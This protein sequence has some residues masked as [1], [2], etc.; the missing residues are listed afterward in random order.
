MEDGTQLLDLQGLGEFLGVETPIIKEE[1]KVESEIK[2]VDDLFDKKEETLTEES[3]KTEPIKKEE[4]RQEEVQAPKGSD[5]SELVK[6]L[7]EKG[8]WEDYAIK[9]TNEQ[10]EEEEVDILSLEHIDKELFLELKEAQEAEK[11]AELEKNYISKDG[12]DQYTEKLIE[13]AKQ[14]GD[15]TQLIQTQASLINPVLKIKENRDEKSLIDLVAFKMQN[16]GYEND[17]INQKIT[18]LLKEGTLDEEADKVIN[19]IET[20]Y[21]NHLEATKLH[22]SQQREQVEKDRKDYRKTLSDKI[23]AFNLKEHDKRKTL[24]VASKYD[25]NGISEAEKLFYKIRQEDPERFLE[26]VMLLSDRDMYE[27]VKYTKAKNE[28]TVGTFKK[29][30]SI[31]ARTNTAEKI[32]EKK[33]DSFETA[34]KNMKTL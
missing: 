16:L 1:P 7:V 2:T 14:G 21:N 33:E 5:Y 15:L 4:Q 27:S 12:I 23:T 20:N 29:I 32:P 11:K 30:L 6:S 13:I 31:K 24:E 18:K 19:E 9:I 17:Y 22:L 34:F 26:V 3:P 10:G 25:E 8:D 28:A